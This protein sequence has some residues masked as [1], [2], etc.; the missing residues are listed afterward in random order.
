MRANEAGAAHRAGAERADLA[1]AEPSPDCSL[2]PR[3]AAFRTDNRGRYPDFHN[4][5]V[6][7]FGPADARLLVVGL[8]PGLRGANR[9]ARPFTGD[10]AGRL[11]YG[12]LLAHG[13]ATGRYGEHGDD[14]LRLV[15]ARITN[16]V[17]C[18][19]PENKP[20]GAEIRTCGRFLAAELAGLANLAVFVALGS[21]A[22]GAVLTA[23]GLRA[24]AYRFGHGRR[25]DLPGGAVLLDS[26]HC[27]RLNTN[28]GRLTDAMF[29]AVFAD[30]RR[31]VDAD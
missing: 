16:A 4:A 3:L 26:Y 15:G 17:R 13:F 20:T 21:V 31:L 24:A 12:T 8:A 1:P 23:L 29:H 11:L 14:G 6:P 10:F 27:S 28:T 9:T 18:V 19:P 7:S 25:H 30:A 22:H 5:P 2:C